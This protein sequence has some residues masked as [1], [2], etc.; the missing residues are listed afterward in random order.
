MKHFVH[1]LTAGLLLALVSSAAGCSAESG[2]TTIR[3]DV[4]AS[5]QE[6][7]ELAGLQLNAYAHALI[8][9]DAT[10][11]NELLST[12]VKAR[13]GACGGGM[14]RFM[15]KQR[16]TLLQAFPELETT[17]ALGAFEV[18]KVAAQ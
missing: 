2:N 7:E 11:L 12:E 17:G 3:S 5:S 4:D 13:L 8:E 1:K 15:D 16:T 10:T 9:R 6:F 14:D 18:T